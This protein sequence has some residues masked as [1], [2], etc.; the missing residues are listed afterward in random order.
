[1]GH[2]EVRSTMTPLHLLL[3]TSI[4]SLECEVSVKNVGVNDFTWHI[5]YAND[6]VHEKNLT[7]GAHDNYDCACVPHDMKILC[8]D[9]FCY[10]YMN[11][12]S[13]YDYEVEVTDYAIYIN[14]GHENVEMCVI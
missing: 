5:E 12:V 3:A 6:W 14:V 2:L 4:L 13:N 11:C 9:Y 1:M 8:L 7:S 10:H